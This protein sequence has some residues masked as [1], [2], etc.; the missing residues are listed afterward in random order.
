VSIALALTRFAVPFLLLLSSRAKTH[1]GILLAMAG[2]ILLGQFLDLYWL[3][4]PQYHKAGPVLGWQ[5]LGPPLFMVGILLL[6][7]SR[8]LNRHA[9]LAIGDPLLEES[10]HFHL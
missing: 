3:I 1:T 6:C 9:P 7:V 10:R 2:L 8:F 4:M 5:E